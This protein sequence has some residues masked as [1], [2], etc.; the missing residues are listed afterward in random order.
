MVLLDH[1]SLNPLE[2]FQCLYS[3]SHT[4]DTV[5]TYLHQR[6]M[7]YLVFLWDIYLG[8]VKGN[9]AWGGSRVRLLLFFLLQYL[10]MNLGTHT[11]EASDLLLSHIPSLL[12][13]CGE[14]SGLVDRQMD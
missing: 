7:P 6:E 13:F 9:L 1:S 12:M 5:S 4:V 2:H 14:F 3:P 10:R 11:Y 8:R